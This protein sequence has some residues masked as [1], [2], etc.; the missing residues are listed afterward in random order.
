MKRSIFATAAMLL[1][2]STAAAQA[3]ELNCSAPHVALGD[4]PHDTNPVVGVEIKYKAEDHTWRVFHQ[5]RNGLVAAR[6]EQYAIEDRSDNG[7]TQWQ[8]PLK[9]NRNLLMV[10]EVWQSTD[11]IQYHERMYDRSKSGALVMKMTAHCTMAMRTSP[12]QPMQPKPVQT[13]PYD[14]ELQ[15]M[16]PIVGSTAAESA[17]LAPWPTSK[18]SAPETKPPPAP[19]VA[20]KGDPVAKALKSDALKPQPAPAPVPLDGVTVEGEPAGFMFTGNKV[21][22]ASNEKEFVLFNE[23][24]PIAELKKRFSR[25]KIAAT[26]GEDCAICAT[27]SGRN[28]SFAV[29]YDED[30][31]VIIGIFSSDKRSYD[32]LG[33]AVGSS[34]RNAIGTPTARCDAGMWTSC[35][36][37]RLYNL[38][39]IVDERNGC[40]LSVKVDAETNL[41]AC[42]RIEGFAIQKQ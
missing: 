17:P 28:G 1:L 36:S 7:K 22:N 38:S 19:V 3:L 21:I 16:Q 12:T 15:P 42:A 10:G 14:S 39:Y 29:N 8:G 13:R 23:K 24:L 5:H 11:G 9:R 27:I 4:E 34:L 37:K 31:L 33:N 35:A 41:P 40:R 30:G 20:Q 18:A 32:A 25:Y 6:N 2:V 26:A